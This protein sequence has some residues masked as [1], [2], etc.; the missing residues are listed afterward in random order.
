MQ[1]LDETI[2]DAIYDNAAQVPLTD[3]VRVE[4]ELADRIR[5]VVSPGNSLPPTN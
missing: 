2:R 1:Q 3:Q 4:R 5:M